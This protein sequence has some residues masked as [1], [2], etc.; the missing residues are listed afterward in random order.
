MK[1]SRNIHLNSKPN[2]GYCLVYRSRSKNQIQFR[3]IQSKTW[4]L[5]VSD[6]TRKSGGNSLTH[7]YLPNI[8]K[9]QIDITI[10]FTYQTPHLQ[11]LERNIICKICYT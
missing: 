1:Y 9:L 7:K 8:Q 5:Q 2:F 3:S 6:M 10:D 4:I 11:K